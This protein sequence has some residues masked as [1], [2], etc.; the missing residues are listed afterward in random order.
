MIATVVNEG[1]QDEPPTRVRRAVAE[2]SDEGPRGESDER[3]ECLFVLA[4]E[5][6]VGVP[7]WLAEAPREL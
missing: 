4:V 7:G 6:A 3:E 2:P 5:G 1:A